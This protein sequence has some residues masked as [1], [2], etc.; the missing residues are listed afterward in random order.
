[1]Y[2]HTPDTNPC[3]RPWTR[4]GP[5]WNLIN[6][7]WILG[8]PC[9]DLGTFPSDPLSGAKLLGFCQ[10]T[11]TVPHDSGCS[12]RLHRLEGH[13]Q[14]Y[15]SVHQYMIVRVGTCVFLNDK[16]KD[17]MTEGKQLITGS[18]LLLLLASSC[19]IQFTSG[20]TE[21]AC[22][23]SS[24]KTL[25]L[26]CGPGH[27]LHFTRAFYG[28][29]PTGQ[30]RLVEGEAKGCTLDDRVHYGCVGQRYCSINLPTGQ[31]GVNV[32]D[33]GQRSNYFQVEY[34]CV[35]ASEVYDI[36]QH[37][38][39]TA[40]SGYITTPGYPS[41]Y[42]KQGKCETTIAVN[43]KQKL[44]LLIIDLELQKRGHTDC[45]D[46][47][48][49]NDKLRSITLCGTRNNHS[50]DMH[51]P[52]LHLELNS[53]SGG[54]S[55]G[56]WLYYEAYPPLP[57]SIEAPDTG[58]SSES[59]GGSS[60]DTSNG[61]S[62]SQ[63]GQRPVQGP[64]SGSPGGDSGTNH[65]GHEGD[66]TPTKKGNPESTVPLHR[67]DDSGKRLPF[68][69]IAGGVIG[70]LSLIL[71]VLLLLLFIKWCKER[72]YQKAEKILEIR[73]PAFRSSNDFHDTHTHAGYYC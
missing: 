9:P 1:M 19:L 49:F 12:S 35:R 27:L 63:Q 6:R 51:S 29:S 56:F 17:A 2:L 50:Y 26:D 65:G 24:N 59:S 66:T 45:A 58:T 52:Y 10:I 11:A 68:A 55:K 36:C 61:D 37:N 53:T 13:L 33:C 22:F 73:N 3:I 72:K 20:E 4:P 71:L 30:C 44:R 41:N 46:L 67:N 21:S 47:L 64:G 31:W 70:T 7:K 54:R 60:K 28:F 32:P 69:A 23:S 34:N 8:G 5:G 39:L 62:N 14:I 57:T 42:L 18:F 43:S 38:R 40:Q 16:R 48:Y 15:P 25:N